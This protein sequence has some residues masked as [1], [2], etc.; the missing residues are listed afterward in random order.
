M[1]DTTTEAGGEVMTYRGGVGA[2]ARAR[3]N[4]LSLAARKGRDGCA[5][6]RG[7]GPPFRRVVVL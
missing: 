5:W 4:S 1:A 7:G 3:R 6:E 2:G